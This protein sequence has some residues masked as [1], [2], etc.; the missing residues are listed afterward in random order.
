MRIFKAIIILGLLIPTGCELFTTRTPEEPEGT[1]GEGWRFPLTQMTVLDNLVSAI[2]RRSEVDYMRAFDLGGVE[3]PSLE[4]HADPETA[5]NHPGIFDDWGIEKERAHIQSLLSP[6]NLPYDSLSELVIEID[7]ETVL[8][9][10]ADLV[11]QYHL[12]L[13]H[14][15]DSA[16]R[17]MEGRLEF[18][19]FRAMNGGWFVQRWVDFRIAGQACWSDL[20][21]QF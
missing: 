3:V 19:L 1:S 14:L 20:K 10:S 5:S 17:D 18:R 11:A 12:H 21:A 4:F 9:D 15:R 6:T 16:P 13:G 2:G 7:R 8:G